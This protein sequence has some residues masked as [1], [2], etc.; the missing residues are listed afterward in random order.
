MLKMGLSTPR[1]PVIAGDAGEKNRCSVLIWKPI[2]AGAGRYGFALKSRIPQAD[3]RRGWPCR[4]PSAD[5][6]QAGAVP[7]NPAKKII[8]LGQAFRGELLFCKRGD[9]LFAAAKRHI[10]RSSISEVASMIQRPGKP[11]C[12][13]RRD[14]MVLFNGQTASPRAVRSS[15][16][17]VRRPSVR[18]LFH[19]KQPGRQ[20]FR[21]F[22]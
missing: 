6:R 22:Q 8:L 10:L 11:A 4:A 14:A 21:I 15:P 16:G 7:E 5:P 19:V 9:S 2:D 13:G 20:E 12:P 1:M 3:L 17:N 18:A